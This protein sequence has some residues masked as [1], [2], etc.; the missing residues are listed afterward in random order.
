MSMDV[1]PVNS[2]PPKQNNENA[3][4][5]ISNGNDKEKKSLLSTVSQVGGYT[6]A[7]A[8][9]ATGLSAGGLGIGLMDMQKNN[10]ALGK[11]FIQGANILFGPEAQEL[12]QQNP[13]FFGSAA[14]G[15][16]TLNTTI[17]VGATVLL[18]TICSDKSDKKEN[19]KEPTPP[20]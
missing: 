19:K 16:G 2:T 6:S 10:N 18:D 3:R 9:G 1:S 4:I 5:K 7:V 8:I 15:L 20:S 12:V 14:S 13:E 11:V 17:G